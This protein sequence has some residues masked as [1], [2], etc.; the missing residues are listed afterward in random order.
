MTIK[1]NV[2]G[3][4][5]V[6]A[7]Y[8]SNADTS[9]TSLC[10]I[11]NGKTSVHG[12]LTCGHIFTQQLL[13]S[14]SYYETDY[15]ILLS[16]DDEDQ[17]YEV[18]QG[19]VT[20]RT[21]HQIA[22]LKD[23]L[24]FPTGSRLLDY[25]CAKAAM[26]KLIVSD[27]PDLQIHL[28]DVSGMYVEYW[29]KFLKPEQ[30]SIH[31]LP[32]EW[33]QSFDVITSFFALEHIDEPVKSMQSVA[34][35]LK[36]DGVFYGIVPHAVSN[37]ADFIVI[38]HVNHFTVASLHQ[39]LKL[40][41]FN[42]IKIDEV[43]HRGA[44]VFSARLNG[45]SLNPPMHQAGFQQANSLGQYWTKINTD[46]MQAQTKF[47]GHTCAIY[48]SGFYGSYIATILGKN[49]NL[50]CFLDASPYQQGKEQFGVPILAPAQLPSEIQVLYVGLNPTIARQVMAQQEWLQSHDVE[51]VY[52]DG[53]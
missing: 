8:Q 47:H 4:H 7:V 25:G 24:H 14:N 52:L 11:V 5:N 43:A 50:K 9:L 27:R 1:C 34:G 20:Y 23:K 33:A 6:R 44:L 39:A 35:L 19:K 31:V 53:L 12:C 51:L 40:S 37:V 48:G 17:I 22:V 30:W 32:V 2:C 13:D 18:R 46:L 28:F 16:S 26:S 49:A 38:D 41:G 29:K 36:P 21:E 10:G 3:S 45:E 42:E 15:K